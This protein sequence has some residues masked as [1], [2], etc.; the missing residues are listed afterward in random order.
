M[1]LRP[2]FK[3]LKESKELIEKIVEKF[4]TNPFFTLEKGIIPQEIFHSSLCIISD[5]SGISMEYA[6]TFERPVIFIDTPK[7]ILNPNYD[8]ITLEPIEISIR[9]NIG[10]VISLDNLKQIPNL[11]RTSGDMEINDKIKAIRSR[12]VYNIGKSASV[13]AKYIQKLNDGFE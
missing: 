13:G 6:F 11:I 10:H 8:D 12:T 9:N 3:I 7:K 1:V 4:G 2:H 5:W